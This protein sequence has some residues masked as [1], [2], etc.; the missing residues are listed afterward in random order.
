MKPPPPPAVWSWPP[1]RREREWRGLGREEE[2]ADR[3]R[4][5]GL[6]EEEAWPTGEER[7]WEEGTMGK[8]RGRERCG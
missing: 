4:G 3:R 5:W 8:M 7:G 2:G 1:S 6:G